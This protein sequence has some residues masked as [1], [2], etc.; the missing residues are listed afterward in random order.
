MR[1]A[2]PAITEDAAPRKQRRQREHDSRQESRRQRLSLLASGQAQTRREVAQLLGVH[3]HPIGHWL[4]RYPRGALETVL[5]LPVPAGKPSSLP[6]DLLAALAQARQ[7]PPGLA[8]Y[9]AVRPWVRQ[10]SHLDINDHTLSTMVRPTLKAKLQV[11]RPSHT[12]KP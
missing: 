12:Q 5:D 6:P 1:H 9:E 3:R 4:A 2:L 11:P 10:T 8:S 7:Q